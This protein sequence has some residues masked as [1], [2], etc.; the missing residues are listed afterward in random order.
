MQ[1]AVFLDR[2]GTMVEEAGYIE[3]LDRLVLFPWTVDAVRLLR[4]AGYLVVV[5]TNQGGV[6]KG[7]FTEDFVR[8][9]R[10]F[11]E[12][13]LEA[14]GTKLDGFYY[15]PHLADGVVEAYRQACDCRKPRPGMAL[16]AAR[17]LDIDLRRSVVIG[18]RWR[19]VELGRNVGARGI[20]VKT[21]YGASEAVAPVQGVEADAV[22]RDLMDAVVWL[23]DHPP[24]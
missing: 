16:Q 13:H 6:A 18:D 8:E 4:R 23:L 2:D 5:T 1:P 19:D 7:Y 14:G 11:L 9:A 22:C 24:A 3:R 15:C 10:R 17:D 20:L 12:E 21:G